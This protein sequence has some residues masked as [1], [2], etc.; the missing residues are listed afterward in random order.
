M[1]HLNKYQW[2]QKIYESRPKIHEEAKQYAAKLGLDKIKD[3]IGMYAGSSS[4]PGNLPS[5]VLDAILKANQ[6]GKTLTLRR[7]ED[8][9]RD[10]VKSVYGDEYDAAAANTCEA[11]LRICLSTLFQ[12]PTNEIR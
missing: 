7:V 2:Y 3:D 12:P 6:S 10:V 8:E 4:R 1:K 5:Y 11:C 9:L